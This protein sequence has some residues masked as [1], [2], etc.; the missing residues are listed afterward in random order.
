MKKTSIQLY[1][2]DFIDTTATP[3]GTTIRFQWEKVFYHWF[4]YIR[5][6]LKNVNSHPSTRRLTQGG[7]ERP[8]VR[9]GSRWDSQ[10]LAAGGQQGWRMLLAPRRGATPCWLRPDRSQ[11]RH[12]SSSSWAGAEATARVVCSP[13][14]THIFLRAEGKPWRK[15]SAPLFLPT[16]SHLP[17]LP[18]WSNC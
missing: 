10:K 7:G 3:S 14:L 6:L 12:R 9:L 1:T 8:R 16:A 17:L 13:S 15:A 5:A 11:G 18:I 2:N 4:L